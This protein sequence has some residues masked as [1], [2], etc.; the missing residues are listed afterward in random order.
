MSKSVYARLASRFAHLALG[1][2]EEDEEE[3]D[4]R[5]EEDEEEREEKDEKKGKKAKKGKERCSDD[6][7]MD[8]RDAEEDEDD[9]EAE[10][11]EKERKA[12]AQA[13]AAERERWASVLASS[14]AKGRVALACSLLAE[15]DM[16]AE[17]IRAALLASPVEGRQGLAAR[18]AA[19]PR[20]DVGS[21]PSGAPVPNSP[22]A[23]AALIV[24][25]YNKA[26]GGR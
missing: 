4:E 10:E 7:D 16:P 15:T 12:A 22:S 11:D 25:A 6:E 24:G 23:Q 26:T 13:T 18:M 14:D 9:E 8:D 1:A 20:I 5:A 2:K 21:A 17:K 19:Q 3:K